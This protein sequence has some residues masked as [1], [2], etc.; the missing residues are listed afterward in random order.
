MLKRYLLA[1]GPT[2]VPPEV[3]LAMARPMIHQILVVREGS[4]RTGLRF[5]QFCQL[6]EHVVFIQR[7]G[8]L[9]DA[10]KR[11]HRL[12]TIPLH[13]IGVGHPLLDKPQERG[14]GTMEQHES[15]VGFDPCINLISQHLS[16]P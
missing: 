12:I 1:P 7:T 10:G 6:E 9:K 3:L 4:L 15:F 11:L 13:Q 16:I 2:P 14:I 8:D 5:F